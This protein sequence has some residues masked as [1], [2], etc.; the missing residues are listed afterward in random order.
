LAVEEMGE[1]DV[2][3]GDV[4]RIINKETKKEINVGDLA[5][6]MYRKGSKIV[7]CGVEC[8][9]VDNETGFA[10]LLDECGYWDYIDTEK[11]QIK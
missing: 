1:V 10:Y 6:E 9:L 5:L 11:Y 2:E 4:M 3:G 8:V 7:W